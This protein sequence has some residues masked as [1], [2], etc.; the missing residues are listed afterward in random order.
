MPILKSEAILLAHIELNNG[1]RTGHGQ[2]R[3]KANRSSVKKVAHG[4]SS[5][6]LRRVCSYSTVQDKER[7]ARQKQKLRTAP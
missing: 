5:V 2:D 6:C 4:R 1:H 3:S 7:I